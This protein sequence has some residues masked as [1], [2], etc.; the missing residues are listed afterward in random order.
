MLFL[1]NNV[2]WQI[3]NVI[4]YPNPF[5]GNTTI[6]YMVNNYEKVTLRIIDISGFVI[7]VPINAWQMPGVY[8]VKFNPQK[9]GLSQGTYLYYLTIGTKNKAG[10]LH[11]IK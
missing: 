2:L 9:F 1:D 4:V 8:E 11:Y 5:D 10:E 3:N 7:D 6:K